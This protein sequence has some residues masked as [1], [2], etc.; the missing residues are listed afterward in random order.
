LIRAFGNHPSFILLS[1]S[2]E[3]AG[4]YTQVTPAWAKAWYEKDSRRLYA[5]GTGWAAPEQVTGG[6]QF[7]AL[8]R[9]GR[10]E[11]RN[12][13]GWF[14]KDYR[15][16]LEGVGIPVLSHENGQ[17]CAYPDFDVIRSFTGF[18]RPSNY[19]IFKY[20]AAQNGVL[21]FNRAMAWASGRFQLAC[22][23]E[24]IEAGYQ[25]LDLHD[26]LGQGT[27]LIGLV[28]AFWNPKS[29]VTG[30]EMRRFN[31]ATVPLARLAQRTFTTA[32]TLTSEVE[33]YHFGDKPLTGA[34]PYWNITDARGVAVVS[35]VWPARD[36]PLGKNI[37][38]GNVSA[39]LAK[40]PAPG[41]YRLVVGLKDTTAE[42]DWNFWVYPAKPDL[43]TPS[44]VFVTDVWADAA[45]KLAAGEKV[46]FTPRATDLDP[47]KSPPMKRVPVF[48]NIQMTVR[49]PRNPTPRFDAML[50][51]LCDAR[52]PALAGFPTDGFCDWQWTPLIDNVKSVNLTNA[53]RA[54]RPIVGAIDDWN[55]N[56]RLGVIFECRVGKGRLLVSA[57]D[58]KG[59]TPGALQ[60]RKSLL[61]YAASRKFDPEAKLT[62]DEAAKLWVTAAAPGTEPA[63]RA[64]DRDL[65]DGTG[66]QPAPKKI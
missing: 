51:L 37:P 28:D 22:Y 9:F 66:R 43:S 1:P 36:I 2:N 3:P 34:V 41:A 57:I 7:A 48:W 39:A 52:H 29:Y 42:N 15:L 27:A 58:L 14:G 59:T 49:P 46:V 16:A 31:S 20:I 53:P 64:F 55:R 4:R 17:W 6:A 19:N 18:L 63:K 24:E 45:A 26:Y 61:D 50:G 32:E 65:D 21:E 30:G 40:L 62:P 10:G 12:T 13:S 47:A 35:G 38:L 8:V 5:A 25:L 56:W 23:K 54:L 33:L 60:L 11:L 44:K